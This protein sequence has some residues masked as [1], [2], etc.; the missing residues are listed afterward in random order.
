MTKCRLSSFDE[1]LAEVGNTESCSVRVGDLE[2]YDRVNLDVNIVPGDD[3]LSTNGTDLDFNVND[4]KTFG[5]D[6][7]LD[8]TGVYTLV[9]L[10]EARNQADGTLVDVAEGVGEWAAG[11][12]TD[13]A[14][15][16]TEDVKEGTV[17][18]MNNLIKDKDKM[19]KG[20]E[21]KS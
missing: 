4:P 15:A 13:A 14:D 9:E 1:G 12:G 7:D 11:D 17:Y 16:V 19:R 18:T 8:Q 6:V 5:T 2:V 21:M 10:T 20:G 3:L